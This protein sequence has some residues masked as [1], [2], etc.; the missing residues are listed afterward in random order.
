[1]AKLELELGQLLNRD[2]FYSWGYKML[3]QIRSLREMSL[4]CD[5]SRGYAEWPGRL[6]RA[7]QEM[8]DYKNI[9]A[10]N[11]ESS[12]SRAAHCLDGP[13]EGGSHNP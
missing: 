3:L 4:V 9:T 13:E 11:T 8:C 5:L 6:L 10:P 1:M 7:R 12:P 2:P